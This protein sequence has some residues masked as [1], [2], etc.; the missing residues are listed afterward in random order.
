MK[1]FKYQVTSFT[2]DFASAFLSVMLLGSIFQ[3]IGCFNKSLDFHGIPSYSY[4][5]FSL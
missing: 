3:N 2:F 5:T 1:Q 4:F